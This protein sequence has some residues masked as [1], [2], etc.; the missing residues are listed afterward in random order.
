M[1]AVGS[2]DYVKKK[3]GVGYTLILQNSKGQK[4]L[5]KQAPEISEKIQGIVSLF[6]R[7]TDTNLNVIKYAIPLSEQKKFPKL[8]F[9]LEKLKDLQV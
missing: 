1:F 7:D 2:V 6:H 5:Q 9:E 8:F 4:E 3:F